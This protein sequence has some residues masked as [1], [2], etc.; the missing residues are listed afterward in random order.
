M[1]NFGDGALRQQR[2]DSVDIAGEGTVAG[3]L[4]GHRPHDLIGFRSE[5]ASFERGKKIDALA[6]AEEFNGE[7]VTQVVEHTFEA[8]CAIHAHAD[9]VFLIS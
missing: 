7:N 2:G 5:R 3:N 9:V 1:Q 8:A 6:G 4:R